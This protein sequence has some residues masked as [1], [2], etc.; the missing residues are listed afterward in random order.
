MRTRKF[1]FEINWPLVEVFEEVQFQKNNEQKKV[2]THMHIAR[3]TGTLILISHIQMLNTSG[4]FK[5]L[6]V[7]N[8]RPYFYFRPNCFKKMHKISLAFKFWASLEKSMDSDFVRFYED[9]TT[10]QMPSE[11]DLATFVWIASKRW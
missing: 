9:R 7:V 10:M 2:D 1:A 8:S 5:L 11:S 3:N 4:L 6:K